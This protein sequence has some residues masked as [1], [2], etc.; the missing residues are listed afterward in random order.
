MQD[1]RPGRGGPAVPRE[2]VGD[3]DDVLAA[4]RYR[5]GDHSAVGA[6]G[7]VGGPS[8]D[9]EG[10]RIGE[11]AGPEQVRLPRPVVPGQCPG[12]QRVRVARH[13]PHEIRRTLFGGRCGCPRRTVDPLRFEQHV[14]ACLRQFEVGEA[15]LDRGAGRG[16][17]DPRHERVPVGVRL[18]RHRVGVV[19][20]RPYR[21]SPGLRPELARHLVR[22]AHR[23][24]PLGV[25]PG[26][27]PDQELLR[28]RHECGS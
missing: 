14:E 9:H 24:A 23:R 2:D 26:G 27:G 11:Q 1:D 13:V 5:S 18:Q 21:G 22:P 19:E 8:Q 7:V 25:V 10:L 4:A 12:A 20:R 28:S 3:A 15:V 6:V 17:V 16:R